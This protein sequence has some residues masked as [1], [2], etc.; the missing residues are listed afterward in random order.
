MLSNKETLFQDHICAFLTREHG[1]VALRKD[2]L[3]DREHHILLPHLIRFITSTQPEQYAALRENYGSDTDSEILRAL[4]LELRHQKLWRLMRGKLTVR[5]TEFELYKPK[6][7]SNT[8]A[9]QRENYGRNIFAYAKE[10]HYHQR[11]QGRI[12]LVLWLN[13]LPIVVMELKHEDE[14][15]NCNDAI[16]ESFLKRDF[17]NSIFTH[18]FLY[19]ACSNTEVKVA[20]DPR[21]YSNFRW[22]N[23]NLE[24]KAET[25]GEYPV[26]HLYRHVLSKD[27]I[28]GYLEHFLVHVPSKDEVLEDA[29]VKSSPSFSIFPRYH[30]LRSSLNVAADVLANREETKALGGKYLINHSAGAGKTLTIAWMAGLLDSLYT[31]DNQKV[32]DTIII[33]TDRLSLDKNVK[34][35]LDLFDHW[36]TKLN[37]SGNSRDVAN[38]LDKGRD[39]IVST[40]QKFGHIQEKLKE[41]DALKNRKVAFLIDEAHRSQE[42]KMALTM[43]KFFTKDGEQAEQEEDEETTV[44]SIAERLQRLDT[45]NQVFIAFTATT[46]AKT[47]AFFGAPFDTYAEEQAIAEGYILDVV[48]NVISYETLYHLRVKEALPS[49]K[50]YPKGIVSQM[51]KKVAYNDEGIIQYKSEVIMS[52]FEERVADRINGRAKAMVV[53]S[54]RPAGMLY[55][56]NIR[57][58]IEEKGLPYKVLFAFSNYTD[59]KTNETVEE[60]KVNGLDTLHGGKVI[61]EVFEQD[62]YRILVVA[63]KFQ[64]GFDQPLLSAMFL[65]KVVNGVNAIQTV[66]RLNRQHPDKE[67]ADI[68][69]VDFTN[70][71]TNIFEAFNNHRKGTP[72]KFSE[73]RKELLEETFSAI[74]AMEMFT[75]EEQDAYITAFQEAEEQARLR[76]SKK[77][78]LLSNIN[79]DYRKLFR[80]RLKNV[81]DQKKY[82]ALLKRYTKQY[83]F[84]AQFYELPPHLHRFI[85]FAEAAGLMLGNEGKTSELTQLLKNVELSKGAIKYHGEKA[86]MTLVKEP[87]RTGLSP[88]GN[89]SEPPRTTIADAILEIEQKYEI[90]Q[91]DAII[92]KE[93]CEEVSKRY[94]I[95]NRILSNRDNPQ[96][97]K[98]SARPKLRSEVVKGYELRDRYDVLDNPMYT[99]TGGIITLMGRAIMR[100]ILGATG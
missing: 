47:L 67:Q 86:M 92:I 9:S 85:V 53:A 32:F 98:V 82:I 58:I 55:Y 45:A 40:I 90:G 5:G 72:H 99:D 30:Q 11:T 93:I 87:R 66:S 68:M 95:R 18:P 50:K 94:D 88:G 4:L 79:Q 38:F 33:L 96:Y 57:T 21:R 8:T 42:G 84:I 35:D 1:Y 70:N 22:L 12:D 59:P 91:K 61:E 41:S 56:Q 60:V 73:P 24:N 39:I 20:T 29:T 49:E 36:G 80:E 83:Y 62:E 16:Y 52:L 65:D 81:D 3:P 2:E 31:A 19:V 77:D 89:K 7:R 78:A 26:E 63:N 76:E 71:T 100:E 64:T 46:T 17:A 48:Q 25:E 37:K 69:V 13:G 43:R 75:S 28:A 23:A 15:Q 34:D 10:Y 97:L 51:L 54:S 14:G 6:P 27:S 44:D 74:W